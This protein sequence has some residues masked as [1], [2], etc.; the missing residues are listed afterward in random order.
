MTSYLSFQNLAAATGLSVATLRTLRSL[1]TDSVC[2][3]KLTIH[4]G[5]QSNPAYFK[6]E[7]CRAWLSRVLA[8]YSPAIAER[9]S[10]LSH[11]ESDIRR[12]K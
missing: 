8:I 5:P 2:L 11:T 10:S 4:V 6:V 7:D 3:P 1:T 12:G 9:L